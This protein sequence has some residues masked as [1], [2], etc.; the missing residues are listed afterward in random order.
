[1]GLSKQSETKLERSATPVERCVRRGNRKLL[2]VTPVSNLT[3]GKAVS[4]N[5][6]Y[7]VAAVVAKRRMPLSVTSYHA[8]LT[9]EELFAGSAISL[10]SSSIACF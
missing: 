7:L 10:G 8:E 2:F 3:L 5:S 6:L 1:M 4:T 9:I